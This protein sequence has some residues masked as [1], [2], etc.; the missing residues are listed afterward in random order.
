M[1]TSH[2]DEGTIQAYLDGELGAEAAARASAHLADCP[3]CAGAEAEARSETSLLAAAFVADDSLVIPTEVL[4]ARI[5]AAVAR[6]EEAAPAGGAAT[7]ASRRGSF[8]APL[9]ELFAFTPGRAA[10]FASLLAVLAFAALFAVVQKRPEPAGGGQIARA[11]ATPTPTIGGPPPEV[12][13]VTSPSDTPLSDT[14]S[15]GN[16]LAPVRDAAASGR[17]SAAAVKASASRPNR[18]RERATGATVAT[19]AK[20][21]AA[22]APEELAVPGEEN[23]RQAIASLSKAVELGGDGVMSPK[24]RF[25]YE[26]NLALL[27]SAINETRR[28]ALRDPKDKEA[29]GFLLAAYQSK[30]DLLTTV[31]D[32]AQVAALG[33]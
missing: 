20:R 28:V 12:A 33:R 16:E 19:G 14:P 7:R 27:D 10:A 29:V 25:E 26:R 30:V 4:R 9:R 31:A 32:Q 24:A 11:D 13:A 23:Y 18:S 3:A 17:D 6:L 5:G 22:G 1:T 2:L 15:S 21:P 8:F